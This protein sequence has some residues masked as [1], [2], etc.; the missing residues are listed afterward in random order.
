MAIMNAINP[1]LLYNM[2]KATCEAYAIKAKLPLQEYTATCY[3]Q[4][5]VLCAVSQPHNSVCVK[6]RSTCSLCA[7]VCCAMRVASIV[8]WLP[9]WLFFCS[10]PAVHNTLNANLSTRAPQHHFKHVAPSKLGLIPHLSLAAQTPK[11]C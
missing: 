4:H 9:S 7:G 8:V 1:K 11:S 2:G 3:M 6:G 5:H 10:K